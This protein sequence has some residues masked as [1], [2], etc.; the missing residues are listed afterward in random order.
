M[1]LIW[2][3]NFNV[4]RDG[5]ENRH[6]NVLI[7]LYRA[8]MVSA[9]KLGYNT[10]LYTNQ[11]RVDFFQ[12][13]VDEII[14]AENYEDSP[15]FDSFKIKVLEERNDDFYLIDGDV[16]LSSRLPVLDVDVTFDAFETNYW[17]DTYGEPIKEL[18]AMGINDIIPLFDTKRAEKVFNC[19]LL[20][21]TN[22]T[23]K[24]RYVDYWKRFNQFIKDNWDGLRL[25]HTSVGAQYILTILAKNMGV[26]FSPLSE[27]LGDQNQYYRHYAGRIKYKIKIP[28]PETKRLI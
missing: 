9:K 25:D 19:G 12:D 5:M 10:I 8:S 14:T 26:T 27:F 3:Y 16:I 22:E 23:L 6:Y 20:R 15:L 21:I 28:S 4:H 7:D 2:T 17:A 13:Y 24:K 11:D 1:N 18:N